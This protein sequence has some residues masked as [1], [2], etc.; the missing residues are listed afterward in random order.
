MII[1]QVQREGDI[2]APNFTNPLVIISVYP[3]PEGTNSREASPTRAANNVKPV[4][5]KQLPRRGDHLKP[6]TDKKAIK[7]NDK[8]PTKSEVT[9]T[10]ALTTV[11][12]PTRTPIKSKKAIANSEKSDN[13]ISKAERI[14]PRSRSSSP[15]SSP[16]RQ[17]VDTQHKTIKIKKEV[18]RVKS[19]DRNANSQFGK[20]TQQ[21]ATILRQTEMNSSKQMKMTRQRVTKKEYKKHISDT[22]DESSQDLTDILKSSKSVNT[23]VSFSKKAIVGSFKHACEGVVDGR[24]NWDGHAS[25]CQSRPCEWAEAAAN[26]SNVAVNIDGENAFYDV[27][28][29]NGERVSNVQSVQTESLENILNNTDKGT[30]RK[31]SHPYAYNKSNVSLFYID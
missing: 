19:P 15:P 5:D 3:K 21:K 30:S 29:R 26:A 25:R 14:R 8:P 9:T 28:F 18:E 20:A 6:K 23:D 24:S 4:A 10:I 27:L 17:K 16:T 7:R 12:S 2:G 22:S 31:R 11:K 1:N 13:N